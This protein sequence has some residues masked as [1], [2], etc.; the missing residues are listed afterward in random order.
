MFLA[1]DVDFM[2]SI[3]KLIVSFVPPL[4]H[5]IPHIIFHTWHYQN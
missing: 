4:S 2:H 1:R 5:I 3:V